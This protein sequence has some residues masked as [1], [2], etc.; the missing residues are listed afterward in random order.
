MRLCSLLILVV[1]SI[2]LAA[3]CG[4]DRG[5]GSSDDSSDSSSDSSDSSSD[6]SDLPFEN[7]CASGPLD[8][9]IDGCSPEP[10]PSTGDPREDCVRRINQLRWEC[11]CLPPLK[12]WREGESCADEQASHD[13]ESGT[14]HG[15]FSGGICSP[16]GFA[17]NECPSWGTWERANDGCLQM[18]W[19]EGPGEPYSEHGHYINMTNPDFTH[20]ACGEGGGWFVQNFK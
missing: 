3:G 1:F 2:M 20:V 12:R 5:G 19:D 16:R 14:P 9:P 17:Q 11:Q 10:W 8:E 7:D 15:G 13:A 6:S 18:M 4:D